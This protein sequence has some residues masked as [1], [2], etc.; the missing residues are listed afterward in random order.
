MS[1]HPGAT[2]PTVAEALRET[3]SLVWSESDRYTKR[4]LAFSFGLLVVGS[5]LGAARAGRL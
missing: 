2:N 4:Q 3:L 1:G 5:V